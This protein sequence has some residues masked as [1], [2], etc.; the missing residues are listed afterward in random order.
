[1][2]IELSTFA[3]LGGAG[4]TVA[5]TGSLIT[6]NVGSCCNAS[7][8][9][10]YPGGFSVS[11]GSTV[12]T[13]ANSVTTDAHNELVSAIAA[14]NLLALGATTPEAE[15]GG[16]SLTPGVYVSAS[17]MNLADNTTLTLDGHGAANPSWVF[18][19]HDSLTTGY[20]TQVIVQNAGAGASL[21]WVMQTASATLGADS[22]FAGNILASAA[23]TV[24]TG[25][26]APCGRLLADTASVSLDGTDA[27]GIVCT[28]D[29]AGSNGLTGG[30]LPGVPEPATLPLL[31][32]GLGAGWLLRRKLRSAR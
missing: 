11:A 8:V 28:G 21:Y 3:I 7:G 4:V 9:T 22:T 32:M 10:G 24:G 6:G 27:I 17:T 5:G 13:A 2:A 14:L 19:I 18:L 20:A 26:S 12:Y 23:I 16:L 31:G 30:D 29:L 25:V 1:M 15:L